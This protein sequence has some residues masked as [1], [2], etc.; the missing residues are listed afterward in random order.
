MPRRREIPKR[1]P[2]PD[3]I[4]QSGL[5]TKFISTV[6]RDGKR[7]T[8]ERILYQS[9]DLIKERSGDDP[10]KVFK[11][12]VDNVKPGSMPE[13]GDWAGVYYSQLYGYLH[14]L[15]DGRAANGAWRTTAGDAYGEMSG[16]IDGALLQ[17]KVDPGPQDALFDRQRA[18]QVVVIRAAD[19]LARGELH[20]EVLRQRVL[21]G[22]TVGAAATADRGA[23]RRV[24]RPGRERVGRGGERSSPRAWEVRGT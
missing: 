22:R 16:E 11:K 12:A 15:A 14:I 23:D 20:H 13:G 9:F 19:R 10:L 4:Y 5:L 24:D 6:M 3:P 21:G 18:G 1:E 17:L 7:S 2:V 8:A